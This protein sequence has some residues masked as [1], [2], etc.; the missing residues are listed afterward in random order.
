MPPPFRVLHY[1]TGQTGRVQPTLSE[2][3]D[4]THVVSLPLAQRFRGIEHREALLTQGP[5][6]WTEFSPFTEY[7]DAEAATWLAAAID[8]GWNRQPAPL[9]STVRVN[10]TLP[11]VPA[12]SVAEVLETFPGCRT[13]KVKVAEP[14]QRVQD[15]IDRV[16]AARDWLGA[17]GRIRIDANGGWSVDD[18][19]RNIRELAAFDLEYVEQPC[20]SVPE[21]AQVRAELQDLGVQIAADESVRKA[22][23]PLAVAKAG[24]ADILIIKAQPL[25]GIHA[26]LRIVAD[27]G[28]PVV[29]SSA[30]DTSVGL[31]MGAHLA[32]AVPELDYDCGLGTAALLA[33]DVTAQPLLPVDG[34][35]PVRRVEVSDELLARFTAAPDRTAWWLERLERC[36]RLLG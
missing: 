9:R 7:A 15:D 24:A 32:A 4:T 18:A 12:A 27:A 2:L 31:A 25:G 33:A 28:L 30:L 14:G 10:A 35:I 36:Y 8:F 16:A 26:A 11:A 1:P 6:G 5:E 17:D 34:E 19:L 20:A 13:V 3:L 23:D 29:V 22:S 21:L